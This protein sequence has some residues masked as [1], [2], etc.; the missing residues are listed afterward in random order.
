MSIWTFDVLSGLPESPN[1][2]VMQEFRRVLKTSR[3]DLQLKRNVR[4]LGK[5]ERKPK[6]SEK[7]LENDTKKIDVSKNASPRWEG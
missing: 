6:N 1:E 7:S 4:L 3:K 2:L 5:K